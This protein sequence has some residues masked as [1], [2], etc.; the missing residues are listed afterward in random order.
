MTTPCADQEN[1]FR[2]FGC[3]PIRSG[4]VESLSADLPSSNLF[5][6]KR[7]DVRVIRFVLAVLYY[8]GSCFRLLAGTDATPAPVMVAHPRPSR[9][10]VRPLLQ[11][12][13]ETGLA[14]ETLSCSP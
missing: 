3:P 14:P 4:S 5:H 6:C 2:L 8:G 9:R 12:L 1:C 13:L 7:H 11:P 10:A